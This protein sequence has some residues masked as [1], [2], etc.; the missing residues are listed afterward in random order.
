MFGRN[1]T[2]TKSNRP[3]VVLLVLLGVFLITVAVQVSRFAGIA[4]ANTEPP[5]KSTVS[6]TPADAS[7]NPPNPGTP[8]TITGTI[9]TPLRPGG[10]PFPINVG[11]S[12]ANEGNGG[13]GVGGVRVSSLVVS[14]TS[15]TGPNINGSRPCSAADF[16]L[17]QFS[18]A[19]PFYVPH[20]SS[21]L[22]ALGFGSGTWPTLRM[23]NTVANQ[24]GCKGAIVLLAYT[25]TP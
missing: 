22:S 6:A 8:Y 3:L 7:S 20:G 14:I 19:Y 16:A 4:G 5:S 24:N 25:G 1:E 18:G 10:A 17:A 9:S 23:K 15:V 12:S 21:S 11:F 13:T 2:T